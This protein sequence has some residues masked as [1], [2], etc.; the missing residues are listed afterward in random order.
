MLWPV[1]NFS[2]SPAAAE[3][4]SLKQSSQKTPEKLKNLNAPLKATT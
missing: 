1:A 2:V 3:L 4:A